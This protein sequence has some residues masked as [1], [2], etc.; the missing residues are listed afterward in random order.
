M[1]DYERSTTVDLPAERVFAFL[2]DVENLPRYF[3]RMTQAHPAG[4]E[5]VEVEAKLPP[6][7]AADGPATVHG[8]AWFRVH[9]EDRRIEWGAEGEHEYHG[10]LEV[11]GDDAS[12]TVL[13]RVHTQH[14][15]PDQINASLD[16]T[17][18]NITRLA[19]E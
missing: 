12:S 16:Q 19:G 2:S 11:D 8:E 1:G 18:E 13:V 5:S 17:L 9:E 6:G 14:D 15:E 4:G 3:D 10:E 7:A